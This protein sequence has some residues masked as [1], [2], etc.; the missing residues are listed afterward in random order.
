MQCEAAVVA[1]YEQS[2]S[3]RPKESE[4]DNCPQDA[5][6][7]TN[8]SKGKGKGNGKKIISK[9][10][11]PAEC[12]LCRRRRELE[13]PAAK[14]LWPIGSVRVDDDQCFDVHMRMD[15]NPDIDAIQMMFVKRTSYPKPPINYPK[16]LT[17]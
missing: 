12:S 3:S 11:K 1:S 8:K 13:M 15:K 9:H 10:N 6:H 14:K 4:I 5:G 16:P 2:A 17:G 7:A